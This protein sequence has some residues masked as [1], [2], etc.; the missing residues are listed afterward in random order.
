VT[1]HNTMPLRQDNLA[2]SIIHAI[3]WTALIVAP[4]FLGVLATFFVIRGFSGGFLSGLRS[5]AAVLLPL[6]ILTFV[7]APRLSRDRTDEGAAPGHR[8]PA[9]WRHYPCGRP[10]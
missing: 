5:F 4:G 7:V 9:G 8:V 1:T 10:P 3:L 6:M 2:R